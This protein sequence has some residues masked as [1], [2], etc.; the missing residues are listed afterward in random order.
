MFIPLG[1]QTVVVLIGNSEQNAFP[2]YYSCIVEDPDRDIII[3]INPESPEYSGLKAALCKNEPD[4]YDIKTTEVNPQSTTGTGG[5]AAFVEIY[6]WNGSDASYVSYKIYL[7]I[8]RVLIIFCES[9]YD[10]DNTLP[11]RLMHG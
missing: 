9:A 10:I 5:Y 7:L 8:H 6:N 4:G 3:I 11:D 1:I 2:G